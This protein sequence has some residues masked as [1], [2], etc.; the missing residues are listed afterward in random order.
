MAFGI[1][2]TREHFGERYPP[3]PTNVKQFQGADLTR[4]RQPILGSLLF[5]VQQENDITLTS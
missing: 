4:K 3:P 5:L 2:T 1:K